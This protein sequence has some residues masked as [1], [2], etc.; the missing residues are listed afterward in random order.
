MIAAAT[1]IKCLDW[2]NEELQDHRRQSDADLIDHVTEDE[3]SPNASAVRMEEQQQQG[4][5]GV[6]VTDDH[7]MAQLTTE[8][9]LL[10]AE[11]QAETKRTNT[12]LRAALKLQKSKTAELLEGLA[13]EENRGGQPPLQPQQQL[14]QQQQSAM[15]QVQQ[16]KV[17]FLR[18]DADKSGFIDGTELQQLLADMGRTEVDPA[19]L[20]RHA[21]DTSGSYDFDQ[22]AA[23][24][25][26]LIGG[27]GVLVHKLVL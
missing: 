13:S 15:E 1:L 2:C 26:E 9:E 19:I 5:M 8:S 11:L 10:Q 22:F 25:N 20:E 6:S 4:V 17:M 7:R 3:G 21:T 24:Y 27:G 14:Q 16:A 18:Y 12:A 23:L